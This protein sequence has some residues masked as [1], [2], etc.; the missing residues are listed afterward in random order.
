[1]TSPQ[2]PPGPRRPP[3]RPGGRE[4]PHAV[5]HQ[6][7]CRAVVVLLRDL[8]GATE[9]DIEIGAS[10]A[11]VD[12]LAHLFANYLAELAQDAVLHAESAG[13]AAVNF[14]DLARVLGHHAIAPSSL[15]PLTTGRAAPTALAPP[16]P[17]DPPTTLAPPSLPPPLPLS[18]PPSALTINPPRSPTVVERL[19]ATYAASSSLAAP[20]P[21]PTDLVIPISDVFGARLDLTARTLFGPRTRAGN[22]HAFLALLTGNSDAAAARDAA[23]V[24]SSDGHGEVRI[25]RDPGQVIPILAP[26]EADGGARRPASVPPSCPPFP[27]SHTYKRTMVMELHASHMHRAELLAE[28]RDH[29]D[30]A[31][32]RLMA[33]H[34]ALFPQSRRHLLPHILDSD[35]WWTRTPAVIDGEEAGEPRLPDVFSAPAP[36]PPPPMP[37]LVITDR[38]AAAIAPPTEATGTTPALATG[39]TANGPTTTAT[40]PAPAPAS[41]EPAAAAPKRRLHVTLSEPR[42]HPT[43]PTAATAAAVPSNSTTSLPPRP[44]GVRPISL[45]ADSAA[46]APPP[47]PP[48]PALR[49]PGSAA[50]M[51]SGLVHPMVAAAAAAA[52]AASAPP[53][54]PA[55]PLASAPGPPLRLK[56]NIG[57]LRAATSP[58]PQPTPPPLNGHAPSS[59][60]H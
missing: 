29:V 2:P 16:I 41:T 38:S 46:A 53:P 49:A 28:Q 30:A 52:A 36:P 20:I 5:G 13:R 57:G 10:Q 42:A 21:A 17:L 7:L 14:P 26:T 37:R 35:K 40:A 60:Y 22:E 43:T 6:W 47:L 25:V 59:A 31:L 39:P 11:V 8:V 3:P 54:G 45:L 1:M 18:I 9:P 15:V 24:P 32:R 19:H 44:T 34:P 33:H 27:P 55:A 50:N 12:T 58:P 4:A 48:T 56:L 23:V 51:T